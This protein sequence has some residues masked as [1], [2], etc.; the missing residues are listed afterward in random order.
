M[1]VVLAAAA[2]IAGR[3]N[4]PIGV[5]A[6][7]AAGKVVLD[8]LAGRGKER[9]E[10]DAVL[11][12]VRT[13]APSSRDLPR[14]RDLAPR[15]F[16]VHD[17]VVG[18]DYV[19]RDREADAQRILDQGKPLLTLGGS[20]A[21]K[22]RMAV[23]LLSRCC[24]DRPVLMPDRA[25]VVADL[26]RRGG[27]LSGGVLWLDDLRG[28]TRGYASRRRRRRSRRGDDQPRGAARVAGGHRGG[29]AVVPQG[30]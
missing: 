18:L 26:D 1:A 8:H 13:S 6:A 2:A 15:A 5:A 4:E 19:P 24:P 12:K 25:G 21:G 9:D 17:P 11:R 16:G 14:V 3:L 27:P 20:M 23:E 30:R 7:A 22:T 10:H 29:R 28:A